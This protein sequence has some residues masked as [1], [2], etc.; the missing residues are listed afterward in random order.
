M[1]IVFSTMI[2]CRHIGKFLNY[3][4]YLLAFRFALCALPNG[5]REPRDVVVYQAIIEPFL[6]QGTHGTGKTWKIAKKILSGNTQG[7]WKFCQNTGKT[8]G[9]LSK[10][11][12]NRE[13]C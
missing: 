11:R 8:Q 5:Q 2:F 9:I 4:F 7:I 13:F 1:S 10:H 3:H 12:E 6:L